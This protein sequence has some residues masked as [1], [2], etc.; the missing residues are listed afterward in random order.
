MI[1][2]R[3]AGCRC[4]VAAMLHVSAARAGV[5]TTDPTLGLSGEYSTNPAL[6]DAAHTA[7][8]HG[9][10]LL[11]APTAYTADAAK[12]FIDPSFRLSNSSG[13]S[14]IAS[15]YAHLTV[16][17]QISTELNLL[18]LTGQLSRD[19]S[20][21]YNYSVDGSTGVRRDTT[22]F[23][24]VWTRSLTERVK[25]NLDVNPSRVLYGDTGNLTTLTDYRYTNAAPSVVWS[26]AERTSLSLVGGVGLYDST[27][28]RTKSTNSQL[29][30]GFSRQLDSLWTLTTNA[31]YSR[32]SNRIDEYFGG[33][34]L[35]TFKS[36]NTGSV[37]STNLTR[38]GEMIAATASASRSVVPTGFAFL[39]R[40]DTYELSA[41]YPRTE[42]W[43]FDGHVRWLKSLEP[44]VFGP[45][46]SQ[47]YL[48]FGF[49]ANWLLTE[50][51]T[52]KVSATHV[53][54]RY[55]PPPES[56]A[57]S[58]VALQLTRK[59]NSIVWHTRAP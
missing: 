35:G 51:W 4:V 30:L 57:A 9:A 48:D 28:G 18:S 29:Q 25:F 33:F 14:S 46:A 24:A 11:D 50:H 43:S 37:F 17:G 52:F 16:G 58:G 7:E 10:L 12:V 27:S 40:Q 45:T 21:Y 23:D 42:R 36:S 13:Y 59:F 47:S 41:V 19:S 49:S 32:E 22:A 20:L 5:W 2:S 26:P 54:A 56:V 1:F 6:I 15:D 53:T 55:L 38:Q 3:W 44:Q 31:G 8:T 34:F 39:A